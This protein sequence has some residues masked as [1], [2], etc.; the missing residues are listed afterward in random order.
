MNLVKSQCLYFSGFKHIIELVKGYL[1]SYK[2]ENGV[3]LGRPK[4][5][6]K[7]KLDVFKL[8]IEALLANGSTQRFI[9]NRY[10]TTESNLHNW[11]HKRGIKK[12]VITI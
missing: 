10:G 12:P 2:K 1:N 6:G 8:E 9:S 3:I 4:G 7:S 11:M 5:P